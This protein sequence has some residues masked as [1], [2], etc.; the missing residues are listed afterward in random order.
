MLKYMFGSIC[1]VLFCL[2]VLASAI[3]VDFSEPI[4]V[5]NNPNV[6]DTLSVIAVDQFGIVHI[7]WMG[8]L[9]SPDSPEGV[10]TDVF[11][12][13]NEG[14][15]FGVPVRI[16]TP[17]RL[18]FS[19]DM[20]FQTDLDNATVSADLQ[21]EFHK[22]GISLSTNPTFTTV[23]VIEEGVRWRI[24]NFYKNIY[25]VKKENDKLNVYAE[26]FYSKQISIA[27]DNSGAAHIAYTR[28]A[29]QTSPLWGDYVYYIN[30]A[31][32]SFCEPILLADE[33]YPGKP[34]IGLDSAGN[35]HIAYDTSFD[36]IYYLNN[37]SGNFNEA[38][39]VAGDDGVEPQLKIDQNNKVHIVYEEGGGG[40]YYVNNV[41]GV[42][43]SPLSISIEQHSGY[44]PTIAID[45]DGYI[46]IA[47][48]SEWVGGEVY[49]LNNIAGT[50]GDPVMAITKG[51]SPQRLS[52]AIDSH[53]NAHIAYA[54]IGAW[55]LGYANNIGGSF[56]ST[57]F[58][59]VDKPLEQIVKPARSCWFDVDDLDR[60]HFTFYYW[61]IE[62]ETY[63]ILGSIEL[64]NDIS[65]KPG[66]NLISYPIQPMNN[67]VGNVL[68]SIVGKYNSLFAYNTQTNS[69]QYYIVTDGTPIINDLT[70][71]DPNKG[72]WINMKED[73]TLTVTEGD[74]IQTR[75]IPLVE[76]WNLVGYN[77]TAPMNVL[78]C[79]ESIKNELISVWE[80]NPIRGW[81]WYVPDITEGSNLVFMKPGKGYWIQVGSFC[82]WE[83]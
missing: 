47:Y 11:Y 67:S 12:A 27:V 6:I 65:L 21:K 25:G 2:C 82:T 71:I 10:G 53:G 34:S 22:Y 36:G 56:H 48:L 59:E 33:E 43:T 31:G 66:W 17:S 70:I 5:S 7:A 29:D 75:S 3:S 32:G 58:M 38:I 63:Y 60:L 55:D 80:Y 77:S 57:R 52:L 54:M 15:I 49:Y 61:D 79:M 39:T 24:T 76:G 37:I 26:K 9:L 64:P 83:Y 46:H 40:V 35:V 81:S 69:W 44:Y 68:A 18:L 20:K 13:N 62:P 50:F 78:E 14:G 51:S 74:V 16:E 45:N 30:N 72:Y 28:S 23:A 4:N 73:A 42:F 41:D 8:T 19:M 1:I